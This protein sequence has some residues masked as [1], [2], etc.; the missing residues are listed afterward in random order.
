MRYIILLAGAFA[1]VAAAPAARRPI[2]AIVD[3]G[4]AVTPELQA[5]LK[6]EY[7]LASLPG[8]PAFHPRF[9]HGTMVATILN[10][11]AKGGV[12]ILSLRIDDPAGCPVDQNPP[13]QPSAEP[14]AAAIDKAVALKVDA[15][16]LSLSLAND[17]LIIRAVERATDKGILV[18]MAAGNHGQDHPDNV[19]I[20]RAGFPRTVLVGAVDAAGRPWVNSNR[21]GGSTKSYRYVWQQGVDVPTVNAAGLPVVGTGT[22]FAAPIETARL[23]TGEH[24]GS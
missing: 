18:V 14:V 6:G 1:A 3:S 21:P 17:P 16:N 15:I 24:S 20:A 9:D 13:C 11:E 22:S 8:R 23:L 4:V 19:P 7:D 12:D 2:V 5:V 10:R